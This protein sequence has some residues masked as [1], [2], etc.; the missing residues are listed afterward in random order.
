MKEQIGL[1]EFLETELEIYGD[2]FDGTWSDIYNEIC[3]LQQKLSEK[4]EMLK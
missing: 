2:P 3:E 1:K 4:Q